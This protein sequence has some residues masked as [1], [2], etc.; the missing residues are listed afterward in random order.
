MLFL[1][2]PSALFA[3]PAVVVVRLGRHRPRMAARP[4]RAGE[5][6]AGDVGE[7]RRARAIAVALGGAVVI[8]TVGVRG[9]RG[10]GRG[11]GGERA[12]TLTEVGGIIYAPSRCADFHVSLRA[13]QQM[14]MGQG[15]EGGECTDSGSLTAR[16]REYTAPVQICTLLLPADERDAISYGDDDGFDALVLPVR[17]RRVSRVTH[18]S[19]RTAHLTK[20]LKERIQSASFS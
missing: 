20:S 15:L 17:G 14:V 16:V 8:G 2:S 7:L 9:A 10:R 4:R 19:Q 18:T 13:R 5:T 6:A 11:D 12:T 1:Q 3:L